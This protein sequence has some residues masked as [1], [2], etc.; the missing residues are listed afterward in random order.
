MVGYTTE[1]INEQIKRIDERLEFEWNENTKKRLM[2]ERK[3]LETRKENIH[4]YKMSSRGYSGSGI[5]I[6][7]RTPIVFLSLAKVMRNRIGYENGLTIREIARHLYGD[8]NKVVKARQMISLLRKVLPVYSI[9]PPGVKN[10]PRKYCI[11]GTEAE[12]NLAIDTIAKIIGYWED[13]KYCEQCGA[14]YPLSATVCSKCNSDK[15]IIK[16]GGKGLK[17]SEGKIDE[18]KK[19]LE[20]KEF[21]EKKKLKLK[22]GEKNEHATN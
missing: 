12:C 10:A 22:T 16:K 2:K 20:E 11:L 18:Y 13:M 14:F 9:R 3:S 21:I 5:R 17:G 6:T 1:E 8:E 4:I 19:S 15:L 7:G